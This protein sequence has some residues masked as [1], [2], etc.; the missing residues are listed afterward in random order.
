M[1]LRTS[2]PTLAAA[3]LA[4]A[5]A[6]APAVTAGNVGFNLTV[7]GPGYAF[8]VGNPGYA[9]GYRAYPHRP[10]ARYVPY[11]PAYRSYGPAYYAPVVAA[12]YFVPA[13][14]VVRHVPV[15]VGPVP[16]FRPY[17]NVRFDYGHRY[18]FHGQ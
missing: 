18:A 15:L 12:P 6:Y 17:A 2:L 14:V 5:L 9:H 8:S 10:Y 3:G 1:K 16:V 13:P 11:A 7:G 4:A